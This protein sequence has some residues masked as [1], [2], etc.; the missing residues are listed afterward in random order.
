MHDADLSIL[1]ELLT[2]IFQYCLFG[3]CFQKII[4]DFIKHLNFVNIVQSCNRYLCV[5]P[6]LFRSQKSDLHNEG[7]VLELDCCS[8]LVHLTDQKIIPEFIKKVSP[9][10]RMPLSRF[11][12]EGTGRGLA[13]GR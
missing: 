6:S 3:I 4:L 1:F 13:W 2:I 8:S 5:F 9:A 7:Y 12:P 11:P 10:V